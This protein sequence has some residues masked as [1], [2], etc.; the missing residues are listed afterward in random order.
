MEHEETTRIP[1]VEQWGPAER[2]APPMLNST[3]RRW[4]PPEDDRWSD[5][6]RR[7]AAAGLVAL[8]ALVGVA[9]IVALSLFPTG[10]DEPTAIEALA[11]SA[12]PSSVP[13]TPEN[14]A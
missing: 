2:P 14:S 9:G 13:T 1:S 4:E 11:G 7:A 3:E 12:E 10:E 5:T 8:I 6:E